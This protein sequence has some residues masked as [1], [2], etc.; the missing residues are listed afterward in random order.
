[1]PKGPKPKGPKP[2]GPKP[3]STQPNSL[4]GQNANPRSPKN[5]RCEKDPIDVSTGQMVL[6][7]TDAEFFAAL[8][9]VFERTHFSSYRT[10]K[11]FGPS[12]VSTLDQRLEADADGVSFAAADGTLQHYPHPA[13]GAWVTSD[14]GSQQRLGRA[15]DGRYVL[16]GG[17]RTLVFNPL[18][19]LESISDRNGNRIEFVHDESGTPLEIR[20]SGE[21]RIRVE[22][23]DGLVTALHSTGIEGGDVELMRYRYE[24][25]RLT[26]VINASGRPLRFDYDQAGRIAGWTD[27]NGEWY[28]YTYDHLGRCVR[29]EGSGGFLTGTMEYDAENRIT[30]STDSL[31]HRTTFHMNEAG[32]VIKEVDPLGNAVVSEWDAAD[33]LLRR[34]DALGRTIR[35]DYAAD[36][37][38]LAITRPD[39]TQLRCEYDDSGRPVA[40]IE[41]DG[42]VSRCE[43]DER[44]NLAAETDAA[45][46]TTRYSYDERGNITGITDALGNTSRIDRN[47]AGLIVAVTDPKG[48]TTRYEH[49]RFGRLT[50]V[51]YPIGGVRRFGWTVGGELAWAQQPDGTTERR[52]YDGEG[53]LRENTDELGATTR[54]ELT[55]FDL[56]SAEVRPDGTRL[57]Y[58]YDT[59]MRL[60][61]VTNELGQVWRYEYDAAGN[62]VRETDFNG[63]T[64]TYRVDAAGQLVERINGVGAVTR[65]GYDLLGNVVQRSNGEV[66]ATFAYSETGQLLEAADGATRVTFQRDPLGRVVAETI[67]GRTVRSAFDPLGRRVRRWTPSG[68]ESAWEFDAN[69]QPVALHTAGRTM[70]FE[71]D[72]LGREVRLSL[73][74][75]LLV[76]QAWTPMDQLRSQTV[77]APS[78]RP[79]QQRS[80]AY[81][82]DGVLTG[83]QD[84]LTG[85]RSYAMD[86]TGRVTAVQGAGWTERYAY[87][88]AGN[89][90]LADW[91]TRTDGDQLGERS[92]RGIAVQSAGHTRYEHD[93]QGR[94]VLRQR[95]SGT[96]RYFWDSEDRLVGVLRPDGSRWQYRYD[97]FGRRIAKERLGPDGT[98]VT[99]RVDFTWDGQELVEQAR[100]DASAQQGRVLVWDYEPGTF[101][102]LAQRER[103]RRSP[104]EW[105]DERFHVI[106]SDLLG[107]PTELV[108]DQGGIAWV[109]RTSLWGNAFHDGGATET[110]GTPLRFPG[111]YFD[112]ETG[113]HYNFHRYYDPATAR[114][115]SPDPIGLEAGPNNYAY[116]TNPHA[117]SDPL[118][119]APCNGKGWNST[120]QFQDYVNKKADRQRK[121]DNAKN[122]IEKVANQFRRNNTGVAVHILQGENHGGTANGLHAYTGGALPHDVNVVNTTGNPNKVHQIDYTRI[123]AN[124][125]KQSTMYPANWTQDQVLAHIASS[126]PAKFLGPDYHQYFGKSSPNQVL[127]YLHGDMKPIRVDSPG[128]TAYPVRPGRR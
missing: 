85:P 106:V 124:N 119:L 111:Q 55:H 37:N 7:Q 105:V 38:L 86:Q 61:S 74:S 30:W 1:M 42:T 80:Y 60:T 87:D 83:L 79:V 77:V 28:R 46:A 41:A 47:A 93:A 56:V 10:G 52:V 89:L 114:Y 112:A 58:G 11:W 78:G 63:V 115:L 6:A 128:N 32:Q 29:T 81:R 95:P 64:V 123:G 16:L 34:T 54:T 8:P 116:V 31:G 25:D 70:R 109:H 104:Q 126:H 57:E 9:F 27:R 127:D 59:E 21:Y 107:T 53:N 18:L 49:D 125:T 26:E 113:L 20:H 98:T 84:Q 39:G 122:A 24:G 118:G 66:T 51:V 100:F 91:P 88:P 13:P 110:G 2:N 14:R 108:D 35:N 75:G 43:Y 15:D 45:G 103:L 19:A 71:R 117:W 99:E 4:R 3:A 76:D 97:P 90:S 102:P 12:W 101:R 120:E 72:P 23:T 36:G 33:R 5:V 48:A 92:Y 40:Y 67:N 62:L 50:T 73:A 69:D 94:L 44:G 121:K 82:A 17:E 68:A 65:F 96:W 22:T